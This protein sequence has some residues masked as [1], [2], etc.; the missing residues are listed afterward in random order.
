MFYLDR[1]GTLAK[2]RHDELLARCAAARIAAQHRNLP[3]TRRMARPVGRALVHVGALLMR[4]GRSEG[5]VVV[6]RRHP[7]ARTAALN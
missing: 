7:G 1:D 2:Q 5:A 4:Y 6:E 3:V